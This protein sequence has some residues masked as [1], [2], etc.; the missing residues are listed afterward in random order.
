MDPKNTQIMDNCIWALSEEFGINRKPTIHFGNLILEE[1][2]KSGRKEYILFAEKL[3]NVL[4]TN[5]EEILPTKYEAVFALK[6]W[7]EK[8]IFLAEWKK[9]NK[10]KIDRIWLGEEEFYTFLNSTVWKERLN[11][12]IEKFDS[13]MRE[14]MVVEDLM[15]IMKAKS[16]ERMM[17]NL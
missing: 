17:K 6:N 7:Y 3:N 10:D 11:L 2:S 4:L 16:W 8:M 5:F 14:K 13:I 15:K 1:L 12:I 9:E